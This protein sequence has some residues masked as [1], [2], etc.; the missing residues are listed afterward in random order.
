[1][2]SSLII[3][4]LVVAWLV[5]LVPMFARKRQEVVTTADS[6]LA[7]RVVRSGAACSRMEAHAMSEVADERDRMRSESVEEDGLTEELPLPEDGAGGYGDEL[8][9]DFMAD[10]E[11]LEVVHADDLPGA[12][13][14]YRPGR[15]G[16]DPEAAEMD[17]LARY[18]HRRRAVFTL[19][20]AAVASALFA[21]VAWQAAWWLH[22]VID[23]GLV[24]YLTYLRRQVR[25]E[26]EIRQRRLARMRAARREYDGAEREQRTWE[27]EVERSS[28]L[29]AQ[30]LAPGTA[31]VDLDDGDPEFDEL[32]GP[33]SL[34]YRRAVGE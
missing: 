2:P 1:M 15:G 18:A 4:A 22:A 34:S 3:G 8:A 7:A 23:I 30:E 14:R 17:K 28:S 32:E 6:A 11:P 10:D 27:S 12:P 13:R 19:L 20:L 16:F 33:S 29:P 24:G 31:V 25:I 5:V 9:E 21:A 26:E